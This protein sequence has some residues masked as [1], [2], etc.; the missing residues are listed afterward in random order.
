MST[1]RTRFG[2]PGVIATVA[3]VFA[4]T[5]GAFA[6][7]YLITSTSQIKP[8]VLKKL[9]GATGPAGAP[10]AAGAQ[11]PAGPAGANGEKGATGATG[12]T[13]AIGAKGATGPEGPEG[14]P[15]AAAGTLPEG[16]TLTGAWSGHRGA[17][18]S[19]GVPFSF[20]LPLT[21]V[22]TQV[23]VK[24]GEDKSAEGCPKVA[25]WAEPEVPE[26]AK[27]VLCLYQGEGP[28]GESGSPL[29]IPG[30]ASKIGAKVTVLCEGLCNWKGAWAVTG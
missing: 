22:P 9:K 20:A 19:E 25:D 6:A 2:L 15:W 16:V 8:S 27:G 23:L 17:A 5:G 11:G 18:G 24:P 21:G 12:P 28:G 3:L 13:G 26:A 30:G 14:E 4:M 10:G 1:L 7:K 29:A